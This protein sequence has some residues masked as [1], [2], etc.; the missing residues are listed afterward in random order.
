MEALKGLTREGLWRYLRLPED[1][2]RILLEKSLLPFFE[3]GL[4]LCQLFRG[5]VGLDGRVWGLR[6]AGWERTR[7]T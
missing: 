3:R 6:R 5:E 7:S 1:F 2:G 4:V